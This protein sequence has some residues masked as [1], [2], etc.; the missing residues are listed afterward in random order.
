[1][2]E[3]GG[4]IVADDVRQYIRTTFHVEY[5]LRNVYRIME[6]LGFSWI[7]NHSKHSKQ[8]QKA[9]DVLKKLSTGNDP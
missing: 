4:R 6:T 7:T 8:S 9:Q 3:V 1:M 5:Q 2:K